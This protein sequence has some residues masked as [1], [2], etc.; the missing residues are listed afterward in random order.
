M[1]VED[2][3]GCILSLKSDHPEWNIDITDQNNR[4][5]TL[6]CENN[7]FDVVKFIFSLN[8]PRISNIEFINNLL[9]SNYTTD[10]NKILKKYLDQISN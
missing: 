7:Q 4:A 2:V 3:F 8:D 9:N 10:I 5:I 6:A 1:C